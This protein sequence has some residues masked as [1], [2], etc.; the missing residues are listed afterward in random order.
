MTEKIG[1]SAGR[2]SQSAGADRKMRVG[3]ADNIEQQRHREDGTAVADKSER[4]SDNHA[5]KRRKYRLCQDNCDAAETVPAA[6][7]SL[8]ASPL[9]AHPRTIY[10]PI[11]LRALVGNRCDAG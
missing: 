6:N 2:D 7:L 11:P 10:A 4:K 9:I 5:G 1:K 8:I 3:N